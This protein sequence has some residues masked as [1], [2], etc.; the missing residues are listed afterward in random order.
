MFLAAQDTM[1]GQGQSLT[2]QHITAK[3]GLASDKANSILEDSKGYYWVGT[4]NGLQRFDGKYFISIPS[5]VRDKFNGLAPESVAGPMLEDKAGNIWSLSA[6]RISIYH[7]LTGKRDHLEI[8]D[9]TLNQSLSDIEYFCKD[10]NEDIWIMTTSNLYKYD[11]LTGKS[12]LWVHVFKNDTQTRYYKIVYDQVKNCLWIAGAPSLISV[13]LSNKKINSPFSDA[14]Q[15]NGNEYGVYPVAFW[16]DHKRNLWFSDFQGNIYKYNTIN[17]SKHIYVA[18]IRNDNRK[19][20]YKSIAN[21]FAQGPNEIIWIGTGQGLFSYDEELDSIV[22]IPV[23]NKFLFSGNGERKI[24]DMIRDQEG[25]MLACIDEGIIILPHTFGQFITINE[26]NS[27]NPFPQINATRIFQTSSG[28]ILVGTWGRGW[29]QY[30]KHFKLKNQFYDPDPS[31]EWWIYRK[32]MV[33]SFAEDQDGKIWIG[34]QNGLIATWDTLMENF[35]FKDVPE[36]NNKTVRAI[37]C[38]EAGNIWFGLNSGTLGKHDKITG[39]FTVYENPLHI[40]PQRVGSISDVLINPHAEIWVS[41]DGNGI[42]RFDPK[43]EKVMESYLIRNRDS[44]IDFIN[45]LTQINDTILGISTTSNGIKLFNQVQKTFTSFTVKDGFPSNDIYGI[46][47]DRANFMWV[48]STQGLIRMNPSDHRTTIFDEENGLSAK[49]FKYNIVQLHDG[50]MAAPTSTGFIYFAPDDIH[51]TPA[52]QNVIFTGFKVRDRS[53]LI[54]SVLTQQVINLTHE[55]NFITIS[56]VSP[57]LEGRNINLYFYKLEGVNT[58]WVNSG[59]E[60]SVSFTNLTPG[61]YTFQV[62]C[63]NRDGIPTESISQLAIYIHPPLW[64][65]WWAY[66]FYSL[67]GVG[68]GYGIYRNRIHVLEKSQTLQIKNMVATQEE[69]RKRISRDLHDDIGTRISALK[70]LLST[71]LEKVT[72]KSDQ[73]IKSLAESADH[74]VKETMQDV[75]RLLQNLSPAILEEFGYVA[76][77]EG[78]VSKINETKKM[79]FNLSLFGMPN[80]LKKDYELTLYRITQELINNILKHAEA[81]QVS[82]QIGQRDDKI[83]LMI[84]DDGKG[85]NIHAH[86]EGFGLKNLEARTKLMKGILTIDSH[87]GKGTSILI[88]IPYH[89]N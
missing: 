58:E 87:I 30:D 59:N 37:Q 75:R 9:D 81:T 71:L 2:F 72:N 23:N 25:N 74:L 57:G 36:F 80:P 68:I 45:T 82:I 28:D 10:L 11:H 84:E 22:V 78:L 67:F 86:N 83:I 4:E 52:P 50:R 66:S 62:K 21:V 43:L 13:D 1:I 89:S 20:S 32:N 51:I 48:A 39:K 64:Q 47:V 40:S 41:T 35:Q 17:F 88:E 79:H 3:D 70:F 46:A 54:D 42:Y 60:R 61:H 34:Y 6:H 73:E 56:Y 53:L 7:P 31:S 44:T 14:L 26:N 15:N 27:V 77:V 33:W 76:A 65:S 63:E 12:D 29:F 16:M 8:T 5:D 38:D 24:N 85:F 55:Q 49:D 69:E 18:Y 19:T